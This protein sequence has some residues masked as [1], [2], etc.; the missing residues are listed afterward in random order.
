MQ[1]TES[2]MN[3]SSTPLC[4]RR[5]GGGSATGGGM[6]FQ[7]AVTT[8][9]YIYMAR[10]CPL[11]WLDKLADDIPIAIE[12][13]TGGAG[14]DLRL[15][16]KDTQSIEVQVK[17][18]LRSGP[19]LW[20]ALIKLANAV[21]NDT[22]SFGVLAVSPTSSNTITNNLA[23]DIVRIGDGCIDGYSAITLKFLQKLKAAQINP[24]EA[25]AR[26][27]IITIQATSMYQEAIRTARA[28][29]SHLCAYDTQI[30]AAWDALYR[31]AS[32]LIE[33]HSRR[34][35]SSLLCV[36]ISSGITLTE[37]ETTMPAILL[38]KLTRWTLNT[39]IFF[40]IFGA[41]IPLKLDE[42]CVFKL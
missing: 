38:A 31:D 41:G 5:A 12:V 1:H 28:E 7:A 8:I 42:A 17:K 30:S 23:T 25:C 39:H 9:A 4:K 13:E 37:K 22:A 33:L 6:N 26:I 21:T 35:M 36:L 34:E 40:S 29:L 11:L 18:G 2:N 24:R 15:L 27:R 14:D 3:D 32:R 10:G 16:L 19:D 20:E